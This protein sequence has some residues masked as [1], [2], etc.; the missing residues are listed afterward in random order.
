MSVKISVVVPVYNTEKYIDE[1]VASLVSQ[2]VFGEM[3]IILVDDG[4]PDSSPAKCDAYAE[5]YENI[6]VI[7]QNNSGVSAARNAGIG[8]SNGKYI[9]FVDSDDTVTSDMFERLLA[10]A[11]SV[12]AD[13][14]FCGFDFDAADGLQIIKYPFDDGRL[15]EK[16]DIKNV[17]GS[18]MLRNANFNTLCTKLFSADKI[19]QNS[20]DLCV[21]KKQG[22]DRQFVLDF[23]VVCDSFC[24]LDFVGYHYRRVESSAVHTARES[25]VRD[26][27]E[28]N[29]SDEIQFCKIGYEKYEFMKQKAGL[30]S[31]Q[32]VGA[33]CHIVDRM[34]GDR[35]KKA[36]KD[37]T[38][39]SNVQSF[40]QN[41]SD[42]IK[43]ES[44]P[45]NIMLLS[46]IADK[47]NAKIIRE[48]KKLNLKAR[49]YTAL[50]GLRK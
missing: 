8:A 15:Y 17:L 2:S 45:F 10:T 25:I 7:H 50:K 42:E 40:L 26:I 14:C 35:R 46:L 47:N 27:W 37:L 11:E 33:A 20:L 24:Y 28:Q 32:I 5:K 41:Y 16:N 13:M 43:K 21:G 49:I 4:S 31:V 36:L 39:N 23:L 48:I 30:I 29:A 44:T 18:Y 9:G 34:S 12:D 3:E 19:K 6:K 22:E 38:E 1:C